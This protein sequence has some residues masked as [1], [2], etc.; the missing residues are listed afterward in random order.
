MTW[1]LWKDLSPGDMVGVSFS[2]RSMVRL[3]PDGRSYAYP[4]VRSQSQ[5]YVA[6]GLR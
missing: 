5:L 1:A 6:D 2:S 3:T 4:Y